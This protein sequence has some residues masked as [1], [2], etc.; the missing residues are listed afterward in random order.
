MKTPFDI[1]EEEKFESLSLSPAGSSA[2]ATRF[3][4]ELRAA[5]PK[6][7]ILEGQEQEGFTQVPEL[8]DDSTIDVESPMA[9]FIKGRTIAK[10]LEGQPT[11]LQKKFE[12]M[13]LE[14]DYQKRKKTGRVFTDPERQ[15]QED[16]KRRYQQLQQ[17]NPDFAQRHV[18]TDRVVNLRDQLINNYEREMGRINAIEMQVWANPS[19]AASPEGRATMALIRRQQSMA[20]SLFDKE[21]A[22]LD[23]QYY[24]KLPPKDMS[25]ANM[26]LSK[27]FK[28]KQ[29]TYYT[30]N[31]GD[32]RDSV[33]DIL[34]TVP[35]DKKEEFT[36]RVLGDYV[37]DD[38]GNIVRN[39]L[40]EELRKGSDIVQLSPAGT[41]DFKVTPAAYKDQL[42]KIIQEYQPEIENR[43]EMMKEL[44]GRISNLDTAIA[45]TTDK[46]LIEQFE[47]QK[48]E[49][50]KQLGLLASGIE[51][52]SAGE[53]AALVADGT[54]PDGTA[55]AEDISEIEKEEETLNQTR[56]TLLTSDFV[57]GNEDGTLSYSGD[58]SEVEKQIV[59]EYNKKLEEHLIKKTGRSPFLEGTGLASV[60]RGVGSVVSGVASA[61]SYPTRKSYSMV[62]DFLSARG[63]EARDVLAGFSEAGRQ[64]ILEE[65]KKAR[66]Q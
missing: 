4:E 61:L 62:G 22:R 30:N 38:Q 39:E 37:R 24:E 47:A 45:N 1:D 21:D 60:G 10:E 54:T 20:Q 2:R 17:I 18:E 41:Y 65:A 58:I 56:E 28:G 25:V 33:N 26:V 59:D 63:E 35:D 11:E 19:F 8:E 23:S 27:G 64:K 13:G 44:K 51:V 15:A 55:A 9:R 6:P 14:Y 29:V 66:K 5:N 52:T 40:G 31:H 7:P 49:F 42:S 43:E 34:L 50:S 57:T 46:G 36:N 16:E 32:I 3:S 12:E 53:A 48:G